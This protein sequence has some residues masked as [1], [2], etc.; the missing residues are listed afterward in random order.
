MELHER[1]LADLRSERMKDKLDLAEGKITSEEYMEKNKTLDELQQEANCPIRN[2]INQKYGVIGRERKFIEA[3]KLIQ[4][5]EKVL[6][7]VPHGTPEE[8]NANSIK[9]WDLEEIILNATYQEDPDSADIK[10]PRYSLMDPTFEELRDPAG[11]TQL[12]IKKVDIVLSLNAYDQ[13]VIMKMPNQELDNRYL[14]VLKVPTVKLDELLV[15]DPKEVWV[16]IDHRLGHTSECENLYHA[17]AEH[18]AQV[19]PGIK[20]HLMSGHPSA[21]WLQGK[22]V[23]LMAGRFEFFVRHAPQTPHVAKGI[24]IGEL[25]SPNNPLHGRLVYGSNSLTSQCRTTEPS[26]DKVWSPVDPN[27]LMNRY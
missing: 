27:T 26:P 3:G 5:D 17:F 12:E 4:G 2:N 18:L 9:F 13:W 24:S 20:L 21:D 6:V 25:I 16:Y 23:V 10:D 15:N 14:W 7:L 1:W 22:E 8:L 19:K 11:L